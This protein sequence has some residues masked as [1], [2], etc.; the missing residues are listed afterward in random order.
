VHGA[1][2]P[3]PAGQNRF[4][5]GIA[6]EL[7][8]FQSKTTRHPFSLLFYPEL[9]ALQHS[10]D[11]V[12]SLVYTAYGRESKRMI[13]ARHFPEFPGSLL[14]GC[15][16]SCMSK[17]EP[18]KVHIAEVSKTPNGVTYTSVYLRRTFREDGKVKHETLGNLSDLPRDLIE[19]MRLRLLQNEPLSGIGKKMTIRRSL[20]HRNVDAV[21]TTVRSI[22]M[23][24]LIVSRPCRERDCDDCRSSHLAGL[25]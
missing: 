11:N 18:R 1:I 17:S 12:R 23:E 4:V 6:P 16:K 25:P 7:E 10:F 2:R 15:Y 19:L 3:L 5:P 24:Q 8:H 9:E 22:G 20:P 14:A 13:V 21:L